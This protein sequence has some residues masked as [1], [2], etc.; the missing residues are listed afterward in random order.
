MKNPIDSLIDALEED[1]GAEEA[2]T[3]VGDVMMH[4]G[5]DVFVG[6]G[7]AWVCTY[8]RTG[9]LPDIKGFL[10]FLHDAEALMPDPPEEEE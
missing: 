7:L 9:E 6:I 2:K 3:L 1:L 5:E 8:D 4:V 10:T